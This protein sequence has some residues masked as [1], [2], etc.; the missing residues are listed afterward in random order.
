[1]DVTYEVNSSYLY[2]NV[3]GEFVF[4]SVKNI[5]PEVIEKAY[6]H[7][8]KQILCDLTHLKGFGAQQT[9]TETRFNVANLIAD[10]IPIDFRVAILETP[11]QVIGGRFGENVMTDRG[12][13]VKVTSSINEALEWVGVVSYKKKN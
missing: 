4:S 13:S 12:V 8:I 1:M 2:V 11:M 9:S 7:N 10:L 6:S 5:L 3:S